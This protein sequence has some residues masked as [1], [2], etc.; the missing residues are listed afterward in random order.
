MFVTNHV[1]AGAAI[2]LALGRR[3]AAAFATGFVSHLAMDALPHWGIPLCDPD[4]H[5]KFL[6]AAVVDGCVGLAT[7]AA[8]T[9]VAGRDVR[10][11]T[12]AGM[13]GAALP[14]LNKPAGEF[15]G[16][17]PFPRWFTKVHNDIQNESPNRLVAEIGVAVGLAAV[18][19]GAHR[20]AAK[21]AARPAVVEP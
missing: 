9:A 7:M 20:W 6:R 16:V 4:R 5:A 1:L 18:V 10:L 8:G 12:V 19:F 15:F 3:P 17:D 2:G 14:D 11:A 21:R 13:A